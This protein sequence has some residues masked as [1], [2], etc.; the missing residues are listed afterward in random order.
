MLY[1]WLAAFALVLLYATAVACI[2]DAILKA[3]TAQGSIAWVLSLI[4]F[5]WFSVPIYLVFGRSKFAGYLERRNEIESEAKLL[6]DRTS[7][8]VE[9]HVVSSQPDTP[10]HTS[11]FDI[12]RMPATD[13]NKV[14]LLRNG[15]HTFESIACGL[16]EATSYIFFQFY[17]MRDDNLGQRLC[18]LLIDRAKAGVKVFVLFDEIGSNPFDG[19]RLMRKLQSSGVN[20][21]PFNTT[22]GWTNPFQLNFRNHRKIVVVDGLKAWIGGHNVGDEYLGLNK[23][24]GA[25]RDTHAVF[26]GPAVLGAELAFAT[27]WRWATGGHL[28]VE[29]D[30]SRPDK[31]DSKVL[32]F[33]SD[34]ASNYEE[35][36]LMFHHLIVS[37]TERIWIAT[38]YFVPDRAIISALQLAALRGVDVRI[39]LPDKCDSRV[40]GL[41]NWAFTKEL[42]PLGIRFYHYCSGFM[43]QKVLLMD[44][45]LASVGTANFD[46]RSIRLNFEVSLLV[47]D[48]S[49]ASK[50]EDMLENDMLQCREVSAQEIAAQPKWFVLATAAARLFAPLL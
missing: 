6:I 27:D 13:H 9:A 17:I 8:A 40:V 29:W 10:L 3:R 19:S 25:W 44:N 18:N 1:T 7:G 46:N 41:A 23:K 34:P 24:I 36:G 21:A 28:D 14:E 32:V 45:D 33:P 43:H 2:F 5:P 30:F 48:K 12:T 39:I 31:G 22:Q 47:E 16:Q 42:L 4:T 49:F 38:P 26:E 35:V 37:A 50:V 15:H 20:V 11:L